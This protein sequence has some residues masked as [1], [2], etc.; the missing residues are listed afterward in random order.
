MFG[1][2]SDGKNI[3]LE[4]QKEQDERFF[5]SLD[6]KSTIRN[7]FDGIKEQIDADYLDKISK[8]SVKEKS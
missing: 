2:G 4:T 5:K 1:N 7:L 8:A 3:W 6:N